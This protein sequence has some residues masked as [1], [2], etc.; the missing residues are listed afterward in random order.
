MTELS[1]NDRGL[2]W[3]KRLIWLYFW[4]LLVE[5]ALRRWVLPGLAGPLLLIREPVAMAILLIAS[6]TGWLRISG[7]LLAGLACGLLS[8]LLTFAFGHRNVSVAAFGLRIFV[9]HFPLLFVLRDV[10]DL[11][12][13]NKMTRAVCWVG[14]PMTALIAAQFFLPQTHW[15]NLGVGGEGTAGFSGSGERFRPPGT[16][17]FTSGLTQFYSLYAA[18]IAVLAFH[19]QWSKSWWWRAGVICLVFSIPLTIS[20][21]VL[22]SVIITGLIFVISGVSNSKLAG[23]FAGAAVALLVLG[24]AASFI[25]AFEQAME[26]FS[27]RWESANEAEGGVVEGVFIDRFLGGAWTSLTGANQ[28]PLA[29]MGLGMGTN[30][31][32][33]L[34]TGEKVFLISEGEWGRVIGE[35]GPILGIFFIGVRV[36]LAGAMISGGIRRWRSGDPTALLLSSVTAL[37]VAQGSWGQPTALGFAVIG[38]GLCLAAAREQ[39]RMNPDVHHESEQLIAAAPVIRGRSAYAERLHR[40]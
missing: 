9:L 32:A 10:F 34:L 39:S 16:F 38:G 18:V 11:R 22:F 15:V 28:V 30:A 20:R 26:A 4:L 21:S 37:W 27:A 1:R 13:V 36:I 23:R 29:G 12:D 6:T 2:Q 25:P 31:G 24:I 3:I 7:A 5:G 35:M 40:T 19:S 8:L 17:S 14:L 33:A